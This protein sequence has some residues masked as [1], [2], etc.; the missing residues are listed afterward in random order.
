MYSVSL[1][2]NMHEGF[3]NVETWIIA[4]WIENGCQLEFF[5][6]KAIQHVKENPDDDRAVLTLSEWLREFFTDQVT[7]PL[8][9]HWMDSLFESAFKAID[10][11]DLAEHMI[12]SVMTKAY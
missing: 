5:T 1:G 11:A 4:M 10:W 2:E 7:A 9:D 3:S 8:T 12:A 6:G